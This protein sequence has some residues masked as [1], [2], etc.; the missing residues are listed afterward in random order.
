MT[1]TLEAEV[2]ALLRLGGM[3]T[4]ETIARNLDVPRWRV[5]RVLHTLRTTGDAFR[6]RQQEWQITPGQRHPQRQA[7]R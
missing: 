4:A 1:N 6:N 2:L 3:L 5:A 7:A